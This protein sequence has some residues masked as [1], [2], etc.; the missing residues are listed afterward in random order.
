MKPDTFLQYPHSG[1]SVR[2]SILMELDLAISILTGEIVAGEMAEFHSLVESIKP[3]QLQELNSLIGPVSSSF[4]PVLEPLG[5]LAGV[6]FNEDYAAA[7]RKVGQ[8]SVSGA[9][10][11]LGIENNAA[12]NNSERLIAEFQR[13]RMEVFR[14]YGIEPNPETVRRERNELSVSFGFLEGRPR[15][16]EFWRWLD[17]FFYENY[18]PWRAS[19]QPQLELSRQMAVGYLGADMGQGVPPL[20]WLSPKNPL[21]RIPGLHNVVE[22]EGCH[23][24]FWLEPFG[25]TDTW[26][27]YPGMAVVSFLPPGAIFEGFANYA[28]QLSSG[29][30]ALSDPTRLVILRLI[31][32][33]GMNNTDMAEYLDLSRPTVSIHARILRDAGLIHTY[34]DGRSARH[35]IDAGAIRKLFKDLER[36]L[37]LP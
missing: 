25:L 29:L 2:S 10:N 9:M 3:E 23:V 16:K 1:W 7:T 8:L 32:N 5:W 20:D 34:A 36:F 27:I 18:Q 19:R 14:A 22:S 11:A 21:L 35:E 17:R 13:R 31:R 4:R 33:M 28:R 6:L 37:D 26:S 12:Q 24:C 30:Q 15:A